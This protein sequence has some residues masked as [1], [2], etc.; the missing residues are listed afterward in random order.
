MVLG[1]A[2]YFVV[3]GVQVVTASR[4]PG[5][6]A[7]APVEPAVVVI[8]PSGSPPG[9]TAEYEV[10]LDHAAALLHAGRAPRI[11]VAAG[12]R[13][14]AEAG[15]RFLERSDHVAAGRV[16]LAE[17]GS[18][19][20]EVAAVA[21]LDRLH[22]ALVVC[23]SWQTLWVTHLATAAGMAVIASPVTPVAHGVLAEADAVAR[24]AAAVAWGRIAGFS[25][26]GFG[27]G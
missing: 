27:A 4:A 22:R 5:A 9:I 1:A 10:R 17:A 19:P 11:V 6:A 8:A 23:D 7:A 15:V 20:A 16:S 14:Q 2:A 24:Q 25:S 21:R 13:R 12:S 26:S 3:T 18:V